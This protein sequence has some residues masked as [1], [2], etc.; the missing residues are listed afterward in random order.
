ML[1]D[2]LTEKEFRR[3]ITNG[4][5]MVKGES[6][7]W[8]QVFNSAAEIVRVWKNGKM[9]GKLCIHTDYNVP[10]TDHVINMKLMIELD[11]RSIWLGANQRMFTEP[12]LIDQ[13]T[14]EKYRRENVPAN[15]DPMNPRYVAAGF[16][17]N[18]GPVNIIANAG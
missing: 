12:G 8:Y 1:R 10:R 13:A 11:E 17:G 7:H 15:E 4:F 6:G 16:F 3:Y 9:I 14:V 5:I 18:N 2:M